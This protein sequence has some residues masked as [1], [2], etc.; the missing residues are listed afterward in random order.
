V[1]RSAT[2]IGALAVVATLATG[3]GSSGSSAQVEREA[4]TTTTAPESPY[5]ESDLAEMLLTAAEM[6]PDW[7]VTASDPDDDEAIC[8]ADLLD[9]GTLTDEA[10]EVQFDYGDG[11]IYV[12][13]GVRWAGEDPQT[14]FEAVADAFTDCDVAELPASTGIESIDPIGYPTVGDDSAAWEITFTDGG[15]T[16]T[17]QQVLVVQDDVLILVM[18]GYAAQTMTETESQPIVVGAAQKV[19]GL[20]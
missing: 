10:G 2:A 17:V 6:G 5:T 9:D 12:F 3:C 8:I 15:Q 1:R 18:G 7:M 11:Q 14:T 13:E 16:Y 19:A 20:T 4:T